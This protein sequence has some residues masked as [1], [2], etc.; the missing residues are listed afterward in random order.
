[1]SHK[2]GTAVVIEII[3]VTWLSAMLAFPEHRGALYGRVL[4]QI[5]SP[6]PTLLALL[7]LLA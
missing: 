4:E 1:M 6:Q 7:A 5:S 2:G 3:P